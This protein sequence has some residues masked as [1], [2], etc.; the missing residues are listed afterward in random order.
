MCLCELSRAARCY[1]M[2]LYMSI[3]AL[4]QQ[5]HLFYLFCAW[6]Q[7]SRSTTLHV[8]WN[9]LG[10]V[11][12]QLRPNR[13][14]CTWLRYMVDIRAS[15][16]FITH[17]DI[18]AHIC[19][20]YVALKEYIHIYCDLLAVLFVRCR[21]MPTRRQFRICVFVWKQRRSTVRPTLSLG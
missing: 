6:L 3:L 4:G 18:G 10:C 8:L 12:I 17:T 1:P 9:R 11:V 20:R 14:M 21:A 16:S 5:I 13:Y 7:C 19:Q 15:F 2:V